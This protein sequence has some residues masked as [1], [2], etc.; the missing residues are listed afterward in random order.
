[1]RIVEIVT[2]IPSLVYANVSVLSV[3]PSARESEDT[4]YMRCKFVGGLIA[5]SKYRIRLK[6]ALI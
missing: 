5:H 1:M 4:K 6:G 2:D 3:T